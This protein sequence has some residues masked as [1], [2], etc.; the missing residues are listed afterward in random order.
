MAGYPVKSLSGASLG[1]R[2]A[3]CEDGMGGPE[4]LHPKY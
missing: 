3:Q 2:E 4:P 1:R